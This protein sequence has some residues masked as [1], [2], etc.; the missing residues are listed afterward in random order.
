MKTYNEFIKES[1][2]N[3]SVRDLMI[4]KSEEESIELIKLK[5]INILDKSKKENDKKDSND[6][7]D[8]GLRIILNFQKEYGDHYILNYVFD[9]ESQVTP[10]F[11]NIITEWLFTNYPNCDKKDISMF[12]DGFG[13]NG[14]YESVRDLMKPKS[15]EEIDSAFE[16]VAN[17]VADILVDEYDYDDFLDAYEW[18]QFHEE[19]I[20]EYIEDDAEYNLNDIIY[21]ILYGYEGARYSH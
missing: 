13:Y 17:K 8:L 9:N 20:M 7:W 18:A 3:T 10:I 5:V 21:K 14:I 6:L 4:P 12:W 2:K 1:V 15:E 16:I 19:R 11:D